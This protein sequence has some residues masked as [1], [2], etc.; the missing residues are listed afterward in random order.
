MPAHLIAEAGPHRGLIL[1]LEK[2]ETWIVGRDPDVSD[3]V[4]EDSTVS[5]RHLRLT[6]T[7]EGIFLENLSRV[8]PTLVNDEKISHKVLLKEG[9]RLQVGHSTFLYSE[10]ALSED[11]SPLES[12]NS[13]K[14]DDIFGDVEP[15]KLE[16][17]P[18]PSKKMA[19]KS[20]IYDTIFEDITEEP[21]LPLHYFS[22]TPL[23][24]KVISGPNAGA[25]INIQKGRTYTI[26]KD[27]NTCDIVFQDMSVSR[28]HARLS[29]TEEGEIQIEDLGSKNGI[30]VNGSPI[31]EKKT[32][33][34]QDLIAL[35]TTVF[36]IID[37]EAPQETIYSPMIPSGFEVSEESSPK[38]EEAQLASVSSSEE[39]KDWKKEPIPKKHLIGAACFVL[40]FFIIFMSFFSLF[41][42]KGSEI[43]H[44][45]PIEAIEK[46]LSKFESVQFTYNPGSG[47][48]FLVGHVLTAIEEQELEY[49]LSELSF[50]TSLENNV[51]IDELVWKSMNDVLFEN[52]PWK[53]VSIHSPKPGKFVVNG[54]VQTNEEYMGLADYLS[55]NFPYMDRLENTVIVAQTLNAQ[56]ESLIQS[57]NLNSLT[58]QVANG[59]VIL[60]GKYNEKNEKEY[61][62]LI[63]K[64]QGIRG[65]GN[66]KNFA[67]PT[68]ESHTA[69]D[70]SK[71]FQVAGMA[72]FE[73][74]GYNVLLNGKIYTLGDSVQG[75][76]IITIG[77][78]T[79]F[80]EKDG[81]KY[82]ID[83]TR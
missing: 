65:I 6:R 7:D 53:G 5:R 46:A 31:S 57:H 47:K 43:V 73:G 60:L 64:I 23:M 68:A 49:R 27:A 61:Q 4:L 79:I 1:N 33:T 78:N 62:N 39:K 52:T 42:A 30:A 41:K 15:A 51:V 34:T 11:T 54:F 48:L 77:K 44:K 35:G 76:K 21:P 80:L 24:L 28:T 32:I 56:L 10:E 26:G 13:S 25:E 82:K 12:K 18:P 50:I 69:I 72:D 83:Y 70:L 9:D 17:P 58:F 22:E 45:E 20:S 66:V 67:V 81:L 3:F 71:Q 16:E 59:E 40:S 75:M 14:Y 36:L 55:S 63:K 2:G 37:R 29:V 8:N 19:G 38:E 74:K